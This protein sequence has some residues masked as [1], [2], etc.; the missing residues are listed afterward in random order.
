MSME[1]MRCSRLV[2]TLFSYPE[3]VWITYQRR[4]VSISS[5][6]GAEGGRTSGCA[7]TTG[8][9]TSAGS[10]S[11]TAPAR[12]STLLTS[13]TETSSSGS[14]VP[15]NAR[16]ASAAASSESLAASTSCSDADVVDSGS[17]CGSSLRVWSSRSSLMPLPLGCRRRRWDGL[18][19]DQT[20][21]EIREDLVG[22]QDVAR[23]DR[24]DDDDDDRQANDR[25]T[26]RPGDLLQL[27]PALLGEADDP[28]APG[29]DGGRLRTCGHQR[30]PARRERLELSTAGFG[31]QCST[32]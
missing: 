30:A 22:G 29:P 5:A 17:C 28:D 32:S 9:A 13:S 11:A 16:A 31:D 15:R 23:H 24:R 1:V 2:F 4:P 8:G 19:Q 6:V 10:A 26:V 3:Y 18:V 14:A 27:R 7:S 25:L 21:H 20:V 12:R